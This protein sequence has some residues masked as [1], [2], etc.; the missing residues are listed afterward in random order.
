VLGSLSLGRSYCAT[1]AAVK[2]MKIERRPVG[3]A[4]AVGVVAK[5]G[6]YLG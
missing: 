6:D 1:G 4:T 5:L 2:W 3:P